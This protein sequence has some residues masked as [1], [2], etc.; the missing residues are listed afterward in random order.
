MD[1]ETCGCDEENTCAECRYRSDMA[2][3]E[4]DKKLDAEIAAF[5]ANRRKYR[6]TAGQPKVGDTYGWNG[7]PIDPPAWSF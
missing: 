4:A 7:R 5:E 2:R 1:R 6:A 3:I